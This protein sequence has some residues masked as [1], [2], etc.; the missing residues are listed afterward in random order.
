MSHFPHDGMWHPC[1]VTIVPS[2]PEGECTLDAVPLMLDLI[3]L[4]ISIEVFDM[5]I[6]FIILQTLP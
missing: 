1:T 2:R 3:A 5:C 6:D 4:L